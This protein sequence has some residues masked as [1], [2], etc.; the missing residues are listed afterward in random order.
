MAICYNCFKEY[1]EE[2]EFCPFCGQNSEE[3]P[4]DEY[5]L[6]PG[7][8]LLDRYLIGKAVGSGGFGNVYKAWDKKLET[9]VAV[10]EY[11]PQSIVN[12]IPGTAEV[13][14]VSAK[15]RK[16]F[17]YGKS[18]LL[19]E[20]RNI[21]KFS[22]YK[23]IVN[24][25]EFFEE[26]NTSYMV[27]EYLHG[28]P[29][30]KYL[31]EC[32]GKLDSETAVF[33]VSAVCDALSPLHKAGIIH[34]DISPD[35][36]YVCENKVITLFDF[37]TAE[38]PDG[39]NEL[40]V[41]VKQGFAPP[42]QY[43]TE[44]RQGAWTDIYALG[45]L[46]YLLLTGEK[47]DA[48]PDRKVLDELRT[49][50][51]INPEIN[52]QLSN[53]VMKAMTV[54]MHM[55]FQNVSDFKKAIQGDLK[56][57][58]VEKERK[59]RKKRRF[60]GI[61]AALLAL[62]IGVAA[63]FGT[64]EYQKSTE[65][66]NPAD[67]EIWTLGDENSQQFI[68]MTEIVKQFNTAY[69]QVKIKINAVSEEDYAQKITKANTD[70]K[71]PHLFYS[72]NI[73]EKDLTNA[74]NISSV[75]KTE[76]AKSAYFLKG[77]NQA[78]KSAVKMPLGV[79]IPIS[80]IITSG[81]N[82]ISYN[83]NSIFDIN[84]FNTDKISVNEEY[85][86]LLKKTVYDYKGGGDASAFFNGENSVLLSTTKDY[87]NVQKSF[88]GRYKVVGIVEK[89]KTY[90]QFDNEWSV[91]NGSKDEIKAAKKLLEFMLSSAAQD[92]FYFDAAEKSGILPLN[93]KTFDNY[94]FDIFPELVS[95]CGAV[96]NYSFEEN[97][98]E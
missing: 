31:K 60:I 55:R 38:F 12:R 54:D 33:I 81:S 62:I 58:P 18:R 23:N 66:L 98:Y 70:I 86:S 72:N 97:D 16:E 61:V 7:T 71:L 4:K 40:P 52:E 46:L 37:G 3:L 79:N 85:E 94:V 88:G 92:V 44:N 56:V 93:E 43:E 21:A 67:I 41:I 57:I 69:P 50:I 49:P 82:S 68:S 34:R 84:D 75:L 17:E 25:F 13:V 65:V 59:K 9:I 64:I 14:L 83:E 5:L 24:V 26:N 63:V 51:D 80:Y 91:G 74:A 45:A 89:D 1:D 95:I 35:N 47:P 8:L 39:K 29:L 73:E 6:S 78:Y 11:Y 77:Y 22:S 27:M 87:F 36:I 48:S 28:M 32:G 10:K 53:A 96:E 2:L 19:Q 42:E 20:A 15:N 90:C 76:N 30:N